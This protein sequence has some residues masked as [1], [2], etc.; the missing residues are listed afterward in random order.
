MFKRRRPD[1]EKNTEKHLQNAVL[2]KNG[3]HRKGAK[4]GKI[5]EET[6]LGKENWIYLHFEALYTV[7]Y[8]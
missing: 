7:E 8:V 6:H 2:Q 4:C 3:S 1:P 5:Q